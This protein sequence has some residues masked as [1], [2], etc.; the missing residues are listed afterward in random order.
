MVRVVLAFSQLDCHGALLSSILVVFFP[1]VLWLLADPYAKRATPQKMRE[2][3]HLW[4][5]GCPNDQGAFHLVEEKK[6]L[7]ISGKERR[8]SLKVRG[9]FFLRQTFKVGATIYGQSYGSDTTW[10]API[11]WDSNVKQLLVPE[12]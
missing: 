6:G 9:L 2:S 5:V 11:L 8:F 1:D 4:A 3:F 12:D 7:L 10:S